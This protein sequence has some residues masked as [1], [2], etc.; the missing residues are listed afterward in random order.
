MAERILIIEDEQTVADI[1]ALNL[2]I[3]GF[4]AEVATDGTS[5][6]EAAT[7]GKFDL[8]ICDVMMPDIDG[9]EIC[10]RLKSERRTKKI[11]FILLTARTEVENK[12][13]G[14]Q[15]GADDFL[16]KPFDFEELLARINMNL[17]RAAERYTIDSLTGLPGNVQS[18]DTLRKAVTSGKE[19]AFLLVKI[20]GLKPYREVYGDENFEKVISFTAQTI[21]EVVR[22][23]GSKEDFVAYL[24]NGEFSILTIPE[25]IELF[26]RSIVK[27]FDEGIKKFYTTGDLERG[28]I[29]TFDRK[30][31]MVD[32]PI[33]TISIGASTNAHRQIQSHWE[34][35]EIAREVLEYARTF[36]KSGYFVDRRKG[37]E[38]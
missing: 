13:A 33:M 14:L 15:A 11:P 38:L 10:R 24:G 29:V 21:K 27:L 28:S 7:S 30:G 6:L 3:E 25:R 2:R 26:S 8:I 5:G 4:E 36:P 17:D 18:D 19:F 37:Q 31:G 34:A 12:L 22:K 16:T 9:Y 35:T 32:N 20:N 23:G 1:I